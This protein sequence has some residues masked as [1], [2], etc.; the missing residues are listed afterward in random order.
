MEEFISSTAFSVRVL[1][2][3]TFSV[4]CNRIM[5]VSYK[6]KKNG[7]ARLCGIC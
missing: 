4:R 1:E 3:V 7:I 2:E 6:T 5:V